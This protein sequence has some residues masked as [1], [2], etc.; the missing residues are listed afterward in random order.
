MQ[1][2]Y[3]KLLFLSSFL[4]ISVVLVV[5]SVFVEGTS[6]SEHE[7]RTQEIIQVEVNGTISKQ[8]NYDTVMYLAGDFTK[9]RIDGSTAMS[10]NNIAAIDLRTQALLPWNPSFDGVVSDMEAY[11]KTL[12]LVGKF[13]QVNGEPRPYV[14]IVDKETY[15]ILDSAMTVDAPVYAVERYDKT[16]FIG[17]SFTSI[18][19]T[20]RTY[21]ASF[22]LETST[23][24]AW[25]PSLDGPVR[26]IVIHEGVMYV[27]G[28]FGQVGSV[29]QQYLVAFYL[30]SG[31]RSTW[32]P[33]IT[34]PVKS[35]SYRDNT[36]IITS[37]D[38]STK[39]AAE[40]I[41]PLA[42]VTHTPAQTDLEITTPAA[43]QAVS[44][45]QNLMVDASKL[46]F[47]IPTLS[48]LLTF[49]VRI[50]FVI[51]GL[52]ALFY[53]LIGAF[54]WVTSGGDKDAVT[55]ARDK[56]QAAVV[57]LIM[58]VVVLAIV[59]TME[60]VIFKRRICLGV[61]CPL[62]LPSLLRPTNED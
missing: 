22:D 43:P 18:D 45:G 5:S 13:T 15:S 56:I 32:S 19:G 42:N 26:A 40:V 57:G 8:L 35:M 14:I 21:L 12:F 6:A 7:S 23:L 47:S 39:Q 10:R 48:D 38:P 9:I 27:A 16:L 55:A 61:S 41:I 1:S 37:Q 2:T 46:G 51:A 44:E 58:M 36:F 24:N 54:A 53:M 25:S 59:W 50:F 49:A 28:E 60:Q 62:T 20:A 31:A 52:A 29:P 17:G 4:L 3:K 34:Y 11:E 33:A 30:P